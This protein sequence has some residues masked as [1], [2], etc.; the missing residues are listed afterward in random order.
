MRYK[1]DC[2]DCKYLGTVEGPHPRL[3]LPN[4]VKVAY[5]LHFCQRCDG[6]SV[7]AR[8]SNEPSNYV[9]SPLSMLHID[10]HPALMWARALLQMQ[11]MCQKAT[12]AIL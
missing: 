7:I 12:D 1:H 2:D 11:D 10:A 8:Y 3:A 9:S 4:P 5:D 6:G